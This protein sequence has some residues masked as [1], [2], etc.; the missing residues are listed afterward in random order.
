MTLVRSRDAD[1]LFSRS[2]HSFKYKQQYEKFKLNNT[3]AI[4]AGAIIAIYMNMRCE[5]PFN[6]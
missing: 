4:I 1:H 2:R 6:I 3:W 5:M